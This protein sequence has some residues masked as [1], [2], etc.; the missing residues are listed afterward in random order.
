MPGCNI[1]TWILGIHLKG[2]HTCI[3]NTLSI[4]LPPMPYM[5]YCNNTFHFLSIMCWIY[6]YYLFIITAYIMPFNFFCMFTLEGVRMWEKVQQ[7]LQESF[8]STW[9]GLNWKFLAIWCICCHQNLGP[10]REQQVLAISESSFQTLR[11]VLMYNTSQ[12]KF[13]EKFYF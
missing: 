8:R 7:R 6:I 12:V 9:V 11:Y 2:P 13:I 1:F 4:E 3:G 10:L 5:F